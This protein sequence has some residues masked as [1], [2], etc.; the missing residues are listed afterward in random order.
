MVVTEQIRTRK[1]KQAKNHQK[2]NYEKINYK[3]KFIEFSLIKDGAIYTEFF[4]K[5]NLY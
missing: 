5:K 3:S 4:S 2:Q 1:L